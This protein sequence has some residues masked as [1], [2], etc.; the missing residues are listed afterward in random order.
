MYFRLNSFESLTI[1]AVVLPDGEIATNGWILKDVP[2]ID[3]K[4]FDA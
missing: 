2:Q 4:G 3:H 1:N